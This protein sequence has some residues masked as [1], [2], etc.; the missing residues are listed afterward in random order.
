M[1]LEGQQERA[2]SM[3]GAKRKC[4]SGRC[5]EPGQWEVNSMKTESRI[6]YWKS[7]NMGPIKT[8]DGRSEGWQWISKM[9]F[10][11]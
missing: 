3:S 9:I 4:Y 6:C 11:N 10:L 7:W 5:R 8:L 2:K 1:Y